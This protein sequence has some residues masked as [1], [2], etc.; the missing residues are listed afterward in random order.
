MSEGLDFTDDNARAVIAIGIPFP[1]LQVDMVVM[2]KI[3]SRYSTF[4]LSRMACRKDVQVNLKRAYNDLFCQ[5]KG[6][7][8]GS[9]WQVV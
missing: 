2:V 6:L 3:R 8:S 5:S 9:Q 1:N 7:L 4:P